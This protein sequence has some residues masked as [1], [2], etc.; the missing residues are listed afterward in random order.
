MDADGSNQ[1]NLTN[2]SAHD[3]D[4][5]W[6]PDGTKIAF[7]SD[8]DG[9]RDI[10]VMNSDGSNQTNLTGNSANDD[11]PAWSPDGTK[12][13]FSNDCS[14][15]GEIYVMN[16]DGSNQMELTSSAHA[17]NYP[18]WSPDGSKI[19]FGRATHSWLWRDIYLV[20]ADGTDLRNL[21]PDRVGSERPIKGLTWSPDGTKI[22]FA[23]CRP[24]LNGMHVE[25][26]VMDSDGWPR[27]RLTH[28]SDAGLILSLIGKI[29]GPPV[30]IA[31]FI[32]WLR[33]HR[34]RAVSSENFLDDK[35]K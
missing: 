27:T 8:R 11:A 16:A 28:K 18:A 22:A 21:T 13:A 15:H 34:R 19:A 33:R 26:Y 2:N 24:G 6:S 17:A 9:N 5:M 4:P 14:G 25:I 23:G 12:I 29:V 32:V 30:V 35:N 20:N 7:S 1:T 31:L 3:G 10:Y